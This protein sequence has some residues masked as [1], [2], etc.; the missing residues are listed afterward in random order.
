[1]TAK[2]NRA[3]PY[4]LLN[5]RLKLFSDRLKATAAGLRPGAERD[6]IP[7]T[8]HPTSTNGPTRWDCSRQ[9]Y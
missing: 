5:D 1:M 2:R 4:L 7:L 6:A 3:K 9:S 8:P